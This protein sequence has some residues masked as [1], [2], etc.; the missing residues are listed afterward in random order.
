[1]CF[2]DNTEGTWDAYTIV[3]PRARVAHRCDECRRVI[4]PGE[5]Y[6]KITALWEGSWQ[7]YKTCHHCERARQWLKIV[8]G[9]HL[10]LGVYEDLREHLFEYPSWWLRMAISGMENKWTTKDGRRWN[11]LPVIKPWKL[12]VPGLMRSI[13]RHSQ[14]AFARQW[15]CSYEFYLL[16]RGPHA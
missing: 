3:R 7:T 13:A 4:D 5:H 8:C 2:I 9:G 1:M 12:H 10:T 16:R 15:G 11:L 14:S 6:E